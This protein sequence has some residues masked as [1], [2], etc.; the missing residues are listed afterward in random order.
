LFDFSFLLPASTARIA[1][2]IH[3]SHICVRM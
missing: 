3:Y 1:C 2:L